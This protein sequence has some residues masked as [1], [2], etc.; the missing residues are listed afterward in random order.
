[1]ASQ[2]TTSSEAPPSKSSEQSKSAESSAPPAA[3]SSTAPVATATPEAPKLS[4]AELK[5]RAKAEKQAKRAAAKAGGQGDGHPEASQPKKDTPQ[6]GSQKKGQ[7]QPRQSAGAQQKG[8]QQSKGQ[9]AGAVSQAK[10]E[11]DIPLRAAPKSTPDNRVFRQFSIYRRTSLENINKDV[12]PAVLAFGL[13]L[14]S[15]QICGSTARCIGMLKC[16]KS[17][18][19][20]YTI[21]PDNTL[22]RHFIPHC[23][24]AQ[25]EYIK[26]ARPTS[27]G[28]GNAIRHLKDAIVKVDPEMPEADA[29][30]HL[31]EVIDTFINERIRAADTVIVNAA[32]AKIKDGDII[33]TYANSSIIK[34]VLL[35]AHARGKKFITIVVDSKPLYEGKYLVQDLSNAGLETEYV[36]VAA[37]AHV[38][39]RATKVLLGAHAMMAD[40]RLFSRIGTAVVGLAAHERHIPCIVCCE[41]Y[42][43]TE[44]VYVDSY[45]GNELAPSEELLPH[46]SEREAW[47]REM[48]VKPQLQ[49][50]NLLYD[51]TPA[52]YV[53]MIVTELGNLPPS[54]VPAILRMLEGKA[55]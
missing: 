13:Q 9:E 18:I 44:R 21:P 46:D 24:S 49:V 41:S 42:K 19:R 12:H 3:S 48:E 1:M 2:P 7:Q 36:L 55:A 43:F 29:K 38:M 45:A 15:Y 33:L 22:A 54:S 6:K 50:L 47:R 23:L 16:F 10:K 30:A 28:M 17:V 31:L 39:P 35:A 37:I 34:K 26:S 11:V 40:G 27:I 20:D 52:E 51:L 53:D 25:V 5:K 4:G 32:V 14:S 8:K